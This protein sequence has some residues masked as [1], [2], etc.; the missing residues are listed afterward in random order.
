MHSVGIIL[1]SM[2]PALDSAT[3]APLIPLKLGLLAGCGNGDI[4]VGFEPEVSRILEEVGVGITVGPYV[5]H[6]IAAI[7][8]ALAAIGN[9]KQAIGHGYFCSSCQTVPA[10]FKSPETGST[11]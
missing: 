11:V 3:E 6:V 7:L 10:Q 8:V 1:R 4:E 5:F 9:R 2:T